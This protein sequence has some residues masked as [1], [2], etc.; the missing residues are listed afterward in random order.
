MAYGGATVCVALVRAARPPPSSRGFLAQTVE[1]LVTVFR[2][3]LLRG[4]AVGYALNTCTWGIL[5][6]AVPV[7]MADRFAAGRW[8]S[9]AGI[10]WAGAGLAG[11][12]GSLVAG[13]LRLLGR[14]VT[15]MTVCM[16]LTALAAWP[17]AGL[18]GVTGLCIGLALVGLLAGPICGCGPADLCA[19]GGPNPPCWDGSWRCQ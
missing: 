9:F 15:V 13:Q 16:V 19:S 10:V 12:V 2:R 14:E 18:F 11:S 6:V 1:G 7:F 8:E 5:V 4:L 3:P 17:V